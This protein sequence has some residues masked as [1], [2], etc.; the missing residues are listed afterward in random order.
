M[1]AGLQTGMASMFF[2]DELNTKWCKP[3]NSS[4]ELQLHDRTQTLLVESEIYGY[5][6]LIL[7]CI[8]TFVIVGVYDCIYRNLSCNGNSQQ[9]KEE[10]KPLTRSEVTNNDTMASTVM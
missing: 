9:K 4:G 7:F 3:H 5:I 6:L 10:K 2:D 8:A 1:L